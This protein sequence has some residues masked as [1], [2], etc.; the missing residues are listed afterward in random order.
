M[1]RIAALRSTNHRSKV[2]SQRAEWSVGDF[3]RSV[4]SPWQPAGALPSQK[5][6]QLRVAALRC[7]HGRSLPESPPT[8]TPKRAMR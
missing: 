2:V 7:A 3:G 5:A 1:T 6:R 4:S 8:V